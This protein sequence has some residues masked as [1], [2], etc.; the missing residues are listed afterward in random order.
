MTKEY[1]T[2]LLISKPVEQA[3]L[4]K[5]VFEACKSARVKGKS[6]SLEVFKVLGYVG[7]IGNSVLI[8]TPYSSYAPE[9]SDKVQHD[10]AA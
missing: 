9:H 1:G 8:E 3:V 5:F 7:E 6:T 10:E 2:D 4:G